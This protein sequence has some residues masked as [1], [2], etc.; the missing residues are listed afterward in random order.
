[1]EQRGVRV[2]TLFYRERYNSLLVMPSVVQLFSSVTLGHI[3][4]SI[5]SF[6][7]RF[8]G[9][10]LLCRQIGVTPL[11]VCIHHAK[12]IFPQAYLW[13][14]LEGSPIEGGA[15]EYVTHHRRILA[16][17]GNNFPKAWLNSAVKEDEAIEG[18]SESNVCIAA[19]SLSVQTD[20]RRR[21]RPVQPPLLRWAVTQ[22]W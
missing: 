1:M 22:L 4:L 2:R 7:G 10:F 3:L 16:A 5:C 8:S 15:I 18:C 9:H 21:E 20:T 14:L 12:T 6:L 17:T 13:A 11:S 19:G